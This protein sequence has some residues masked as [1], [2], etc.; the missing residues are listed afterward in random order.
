MMIKP[1]YVYLHHRHH[2]VSECA[3]NLQVFKQ[4]AKNLHV[5]SQGL[6]TPKRDKAVYA[7]IGWTQN[8]SAVCCCHLNQRSCATR[9]LKQTHQPT[10]LHFI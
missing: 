7:H 8:T 9:K 2:I 4:L 1:H 10:H 3:Q 6:C 5:R